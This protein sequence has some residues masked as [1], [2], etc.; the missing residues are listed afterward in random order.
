MSD[1]LL[2]IVEK[3]NYLNHAI[4]I[5]GSGRSGT[6]LIQ[7]LLDDH[8]QLLVWPAEYQYYDYW[9]RYFPTSCQDDRYSVSTLRNRI[10]HGGVANFGKEHNAG[11]INKTYSMKSVN[12]IVFH[13]ILNHFNHE[14]LSRKEFLQL[15]IH[16]FH[17]AL[18]GTLVPDSFV[19]KINKPNDQIFDDFSDIR[20]IFCSRHP[21][22]IY[23]SIKRYY[24]KIKKKD[25]WHTYL[26]A[27]RQ[28]HWGLLETAISPI[29][30]AYKWLEEHK[31]NSNLFIARLEELQTDPLTVMSKA[32]K[33]LDIKF[34]KCLTESTMLGNI[35]GS[36]LSSGNDTQGQIRNKK[37]DLSLLTPYEL[38]WACSVLQQAC[39]SAN[40]DLP[41]ETLKQHSTLDYF[42]SF[43]EPLTNE[44]LDIPYIL[45][46]SSETSLI[47]RIFNF[48]RTY[49]YYSRNR[50]YMITVGARQKLIK[51]VRISQ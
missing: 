1:R 26:S 10:L 2:E 27:N 13:T 50:L 5:V 8:P 25:P 42:C 31:N 39:D 24:F 21:L 35:Y 49:I 43:W 48:I 45:D 20:V 28:Y 36:N 15:V 47:R 14:E 16:C 41:N 37:V 17:Q 22:T 30:H 6:T 9:D 19:V 12:A 33:F 3:N 4:F 51:T 7:T 11:P 44:L 38:K 29:L 34:E 40:Y 23:D 46:L 32:A 18:D